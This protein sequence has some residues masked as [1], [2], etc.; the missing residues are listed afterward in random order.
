MDR[1]AWWATVN[2]SDMTEQQTHTIYLYAISLF[3]RYFLESL[4][5]ST[6]EERKNRSQTYRMSSTKSLV[7]STHSI[8]QVFHSA[9]L[10][11]FWIMVV[12]SHISLY[13]PGPGDG[14]GLL[15]ASACFSNL[16]TCFLSKNALLWISTSTTHASPSCFTC[17]LISRSLAFI[18]RTFKILEHCHFLQ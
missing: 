3:L 15:L 2:Q 17:L 9:F 6:V 12:L 5:C 16:H 8:L 13:N 1:G 4:Q 11:S 14:V 7:N 18:P 10:V